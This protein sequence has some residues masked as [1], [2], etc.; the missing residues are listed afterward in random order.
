MLIIKVA[1]WP[2]SNTV[3]SDFF[4]PKLVSFGILIPS[5]VTNMM[6]G[7]ILCKLGTHELTLDLI[8]RWITGN[9]LKISTYR[10]GLSLF[11]VIFLKLATLLSSI[12]T[13]RGLCPG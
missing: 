12:M 13:E 10:V 2:E 6:L 11:A 8:W 3:P 7:P 5:A 1:N 4:F 9:V